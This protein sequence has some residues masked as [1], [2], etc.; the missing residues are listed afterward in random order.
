MVRVPAALQLATQAGFAAITTAAAKLDLRAVLDT[1]V[2]AGH[3]LS[4]CEQHYSWL[5][6]LHM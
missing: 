3:S 2:A 6:N 1:A 5:L 4:T